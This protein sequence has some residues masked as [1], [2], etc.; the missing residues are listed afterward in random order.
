[1]KHAA[2]KLGLATVLAIGLLGVTGG[3]SAAVPPPSADPFYTPPAHLGS[4][5]PG[6]ILRWRTV[7]APGVNDYS[8]AYQLLYRSTDAKRQPIA[9]VTTLFLPSDPAP[10]PRHLFSFHQAYDSLSLTCAPSHALRT[11]QVT[12]LGDASVS[13]DTQAFLGF[14]WDVAVPDY[15]GLDSQWGVGRIAGRATLDGI[16]AVERFRRAELEGTRTKVAMGGYSGGSIPTLWAA[17]LAKRYAPELRIVA[18]AAGGNV[19]D[20]IQNLAPLDGSP[21]FGTVVGVAVGVDRAY[22]ELR[23]DDILNAKGRALA[24]RDATDADGC[25]G[26]V[27]NAPLG[28]VAEYSNYPNPEALLA[29]PR[30]QRVFA[31]LN[32]I[33]RPAPEVPSLIFNSAQDEL[34]IIEPVDQLVAAWCARGA[35]IE[36]QTPPGDH[37]TGSALFGRQAVP[38]VEAGFAGTPTPNTCR[39]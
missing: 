12:G 39:S 34:T 1:M 33:R 5:G 9:A 26:S 18:A 32:L 37:A 13:E 31:R 11:D 21:L 24:A 17:S 29:L 35:T 20:L 10:G 38:F 16:R 7:T 15:E 2:I 8:A 27:T 25:A 3:A 30:L 19:P 36:Y 23:L 6:K 22:P 28:T 4:Y 14:G